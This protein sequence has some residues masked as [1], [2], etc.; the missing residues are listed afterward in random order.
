[1]KTQSKKPSH[2]IGTRRM[3]ALGLAM[4]LTNWGAQAQSTGSNGGGQDV[5]F[6]RIRNEISNWIVKNAEIGKLESKLRLKG[7]SGVELKDRL[8]AAVEGVGDKILFNHEKIVFRDEEAGKE[9]VRV[10]KNE[11]AEITCN[12][13]EWEGIRDGRLKYAIVFHEFLG[14]AGLETNQGTPYSRYPISPEIMRFV[15]SVQAFE[16]GMDPVIPEG[17]GSS[18]RD[19]FM[20]ASMPTNDVFFTRK[21]LYPGKDSGYW[22]C[23]VGGKGFLVMGFRRAAGGVDMF[24]PVATPLMLNEELRVAVADRYPNMKGYFFISIRQEGS[25]L[26]VEYSYNPS[27]G[28]RKR[29]PEFLRSVL[30][31]NLAVTSYWE[32]VPRPMGD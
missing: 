17:D 16:L 13:G 25:I 6:K 30:D 28:Y 22:N 23:S 29:H 26:L 2:G 7:I 8:L 31:P 32:C 24:T 18:L 12:I 10:C 11:Y 27:P 9:N 1:M 14:V 3:A 15:R 20:R 5:A 4:L 21:Y 19:R